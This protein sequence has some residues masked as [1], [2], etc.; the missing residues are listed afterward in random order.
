MRLTII[1]GLDHAE[2]ETQSFEAARIL[3]ELAE[4]IRT[5]EQIQVGDSFVLRD[6]N[7]NRVGIADIFKD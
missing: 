6:V 5:A 7:G 3:T 4:K 2:P 1:C